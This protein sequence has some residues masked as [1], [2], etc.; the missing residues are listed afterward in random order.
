VTSAHVFRGLELE[1]TIDFARGQ[2]AYLGGIEDWML[3]RRLAVLFAIVGGLCA[4]L[5]IAVIPSFDDS[6]FTIAYAFLAIATVC[7]SLVPGIRAATAIKF[8]IGPRF[9]NIPRLSR[10][11]RLAAILVAPCVL[12]Q[13]GYP[14]RLLAEYNSLTAQDV[15]RVQDLA[16]AYD[17]ELD[18]NVGLSIPVIKSD[19]QPPL[20]DPSAAVKVA[21][22]E[23]E[24]TK[25]LLTQINGGFDAINNLAQRSTITAP[26][27]TESERHR[28][29]QILN[30]RIIVLGALTDNP[31]T[32]N[33]KIRSNYEDLKTVLQSTK[34]DFER[35]RANLALAKLNKSF[36]YPLTSTGLSCRGDGQSAVCQLFDRFVQLWML[37]QRSFGNDLFPEGLLPAKDYSQSLLAQ[38]APNVLATY[39]ALFGWQGVIPVVTI[40]ITF[41]IALRILRLTTQ[42]AGFSAFVVVVI[43]GLW[44]FGYIPPTA[45]F[46]PGQLDPNQIFSGSLLTIAIGTVVIWVLTIP[47]L[48]ERSS[49]KSQNPQRGILRATMLVLPT[50]ILL[51]FFF[52]ARIGFGPLAGWLLWPFLAGGIGL[53]AILMRLLDTKLVEL[54]CK[55]LIP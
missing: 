38:S 55:P 49:A 2:S 41:G 3:T 28:L 6:S 5:F 43:S 48:D 22:A 31:A 45:F 39:A 19:D 33:E 34:Y 20:V 10:A 54:N 11:F 9:L 40:A 25:V 50:V 1:W 14:I 26:L 18:K 42:N 17:D 15:G 32:I 23:I 37:R 21:A 51:P 35:D 36:T 8:E 46:T 13:I 44:G 24:R 4:A 47:V 16:H 12:L 53:I 29:Q 7:F 52:I 30:K 27:D